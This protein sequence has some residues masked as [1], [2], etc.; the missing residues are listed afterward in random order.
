[1]KY[2]DLEFSAILCDKNLTNSVKN[3]VLDKRAPIDIKIRI[4]PTVLTKRK[5]VSSI[6]V[7]IK[8]ERVLLK[9]GDIFLILYC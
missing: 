3:V 7:K 2:N 4:N 9:K 5:K 1:M 6:D 8:K